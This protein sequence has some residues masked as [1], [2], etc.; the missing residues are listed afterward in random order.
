[1][2]AGMANSWLVS[3][4]GTRMVL[5]MGE[6]RGRLGHDVGRIQGNACLGAVIGSTPLQVYSAQWQPSVVSCTKPGR[7]SSKPRQGR[8]SRLLCT[9]TRHGTN[10]HDKV[11]G[12][13]RWG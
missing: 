5:E 13:S 9:Q 6:D 11:A 4:A 12:V 2:R 10:R 7:D 1:M 8:P 3:S